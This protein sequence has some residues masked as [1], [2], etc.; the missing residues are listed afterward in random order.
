MIAL[1]TEDMLHGWMVRLGAN[2]KGSYDPIADM[3][4]HIKRALESAYRK[5]FGAGIEH[6][7][8]NWWVSQDKEME[9][10]P[11]PPPPPGINTIKKKG[12]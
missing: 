7:N 2:I 1:V 3:E 4:L 5:G 12:I 8:N 6:E 11:F 10:K 9:T